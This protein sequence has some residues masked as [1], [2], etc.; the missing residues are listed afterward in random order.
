MVSRTEAPGSRPPEIVSLGER[1]GYLQGLRAAITAV[2]LGSG[3]FASQIIGAR[4]EDL[5]LVSAGYLLLSAAVEGARRMGRGRGLAAVGGMLLMD[6]LYL[7]WVMY[8]TG[9]TQSPLRFLVYL[10]LIAVTL[11]ASYRTGL[12]VA[13]WHS[14]LFFVVFYAQAAR[15]LAPLE[16]GSEAGAGFQRPSFF[17]VVAFWLIA[18]ATTAFSSINERELRRRQNDLESLARMAEELE[19]V[20]SPDEVATIFLE[21]IT[22]TFEFHRGV[23]LGSEDGGEPR[24]L[25]FKGPNDAPEA[26]THLDACVRRAWEQRSPILLKKLDP[27]EDPQLS[28][29]L[30]FAKSL[31]VVPL[32]A[33]GQPLGVLAVEHGQK[34]KRIERRIVNMITQFSAHGGLALRNAWLLEQIKKMADTDGLTG[35]ANRRSFE[36]MLDRELSRAQRNG[37]QVTLVMLDIDHFKELNDTH[38]H[39]AGDETLRQ[40]AASLVENCRDFDTPARYGGEEFVVILPSCSAKESLIAGERL[41]SGVGRAEGPVPVTASAGAATFPAHAGDAE[42]LIKAAD[43]A[44]YE[45]KRA[46]RDRLTRSRRNTPRPNK[47]INLDS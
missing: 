13:L 27:E 30:P 17:N 7:A 2:V 11:L 26:A 22:E 18:L 5:M 43:E 16:P 33:E 44:L 25:A 4:L 10:H 37:D 42:S 39:L 9:G 32:F 41:R 3:I 31:V 35:I 19:N 14:L 8:L 1:M 36:A 21:G 47:T 29:L 23:V 34:T 45:S 38:G 28:A 46:G 40:V 12:K 20:A 6:G 24:L 15:I